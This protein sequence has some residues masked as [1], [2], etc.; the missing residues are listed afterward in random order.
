MLKGIETLGKVTICLPLRSEWWLDISFLFIPL[1]FENRKENSCLWYL[2][3]HQQRADIAY[4]KKNPKF[5]VAFK[6]RLKC[7]HK[8]AGPSW[9]INRCLSC[10]RLPPCHNLRD[11][12]CL[13]QLQC[14]TWK[15][16]IPATP[17]LLLTTILKWFENIS[18]KKLNVYYFS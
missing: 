16:I 8:A 9:V 18:W 4:L 15:D 17:P 7:Q 2:L 13:A 6:E 11:S 12:S 3:N 5:H 14:C 10:R 1:S